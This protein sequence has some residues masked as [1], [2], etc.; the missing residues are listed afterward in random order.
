MGL[1]SVTWERGHPCPHGCKRTMW[2]GVP[3]LP[4]GTE[5]PTIEIR[6]HLTGRL[7][8]IV[9][10]ETL[11]GANLLGRQ[12]PGADLR[13]ADLTQ[14]SL[15]GANLTGALLVDARLSRARLLYTD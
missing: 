13:G 6:E 10:G 11:R 12:L 7:L 2:A 14:A 9:P 4:G 5:D 3:A 1:R 15:Q 8:L